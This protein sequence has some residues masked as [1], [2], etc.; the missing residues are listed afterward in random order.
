MAL[1]G[2]PLP[3]ERALEW[4]LINRVVPDHKLLEEARELARNLARGPTR[5]YAN[6]KR[7]LNNSFM[8]IMDEQLDLE[9]DIQGEMVKTSDFIE[10]VSAFVEKRDARFTGN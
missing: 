8:K 1:L 10:G 5:S 3:A 2:E 4:G 7:A 6:S 9:A